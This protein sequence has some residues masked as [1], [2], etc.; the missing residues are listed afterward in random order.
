MAKKTKEVTPDYY[1]EVTEDITLEIYE[2]GTKKNPS[3]SAKL[4]FCDCFVV[5]GKVRTYTG[6]DKK[7]HGFL[8]LPSWVNK[9]GDRISQAYFYDSSINDT[10]TDF[11]ESEVI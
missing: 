2:R 1:L 9:D 4:T 7:L 8:A 3:Y 11:I 6:K 10:I 5:Y